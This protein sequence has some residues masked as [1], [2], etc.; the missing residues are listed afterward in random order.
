FAFVTLFFLSGPVFGSLGNI[1]ALEQV[2][3]TP[4]ILNGSWISDVVGLTVVFGAGFLLLWHFW[5]AYKHNPLEGFLAYSL[6]RLAVWVFYGTYLGLASDTAS[7]KVHLHH[8][9]V[10]FLCATLAEFNHPLSMVLLACA[11][12][13]F[14]QGISAYEAAPVINRGYP[15]FLVFS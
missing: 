6:S 13:I 1:L 12:G 7:V 5:C 15:M 9:V 14:V 2:S 3:L 10:G 4:A 11:S 8:Y